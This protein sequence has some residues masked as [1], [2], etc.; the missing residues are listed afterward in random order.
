MH[1][2]S[3]VVFFASFFRNISKTAV[4]ILI[5]KIKR[6]HGFLVYKKAL[7]NEHRKN[8]I[9]EILIILSKCLLVRFSTLPNFV[10]AML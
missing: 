2:K 7:M 8:Y 4:T 1:E 9:Y 10:Y 3:V 6:N 5:K